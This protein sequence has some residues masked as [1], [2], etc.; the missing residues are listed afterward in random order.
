MVQPA[1]GIAGYPKREE[2]EEMRFSLS[3]REEQGNFLSLNPARPPDRL[4]GLV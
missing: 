1:E 4:D 2:R 3:G